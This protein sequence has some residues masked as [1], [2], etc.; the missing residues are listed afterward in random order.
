MLKFSLKGSVSST[1][2]APEHSPNCTASSPT[3]VKK[4]RGSLLVE[5]AV[6]TAVDPETALLPLINAADIASTQV[7]SNEL[8]H[9]NASMHRQAPACIGKRILPLAKARQRNL[10]RCSSSSSSSRSCR[11]FPHKNSNRHANTGVHAGLPMPG[12][13]NALL[14]SDR[15]QSYLLYITYTYI[16]TG[17]TLFS[18]TYLCAWCVW[19]LT[20]THTRNTHTQTNLP[21]LP[22]RMFIIAPQKRTRIT[23]I[24]NT[25]L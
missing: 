11:D 12:Q 19:A 23:N 15:V 6:R 4:R 18:S 9:A 17:R 20:H 1:I 10:A 24:L 5:L 7:N 22:I 16:G 25:A 8:R 21:R 2:K 3:K 14:E 13:R